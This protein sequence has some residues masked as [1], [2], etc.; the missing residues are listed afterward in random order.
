[1]IAARQITALVILL[2]RVVGA[3]PW[4]PPAGTGALSIGVQRIDHTGHR[5]TDGTLFSNGRSLNVSLYIGAEYALTDRWSISATLPYVFGRY[6]DAEPPPPFIPFLAIDQG[7]CWNSGFQDFDVTARYSVAS[8]SFAL[9]PSVSAALPSQN[10]VYRG[11]A[12]VGRHLRELRLGVDAGLRLDAIHPRLSFDGRYSLAIVER[13]LDIPNNRSNGAVGIAYRLRSNLSARAA[14]GW[15]RTH[16]GL[17]LGSPLPSDLLPPG[18]VN[19]PERLDQHD[20]L[21]RDNSTH[22]GWTVSYHFTRVNVFGSYV[23]F[24][25]GSDTHAGRAMT[26]GISWPFELRR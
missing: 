14:V 20:R 24:M 3:Q 23:A 9:T 10:Y 15:Q 7:R 26:T 11:E 6:T 13:V 4:V 21:L 19:T 18:E 16:G 2:P 1:M 8:G 22:V 5:V 17:R 12:A 25:E